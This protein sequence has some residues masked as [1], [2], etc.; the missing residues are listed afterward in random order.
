MTRAEVLEFLELPA[1]NVTDLQ[2]RQRLQEKAGY[3]ED[4]SKNAN[5][6]FL[7][8]VHSR[9]WMKVQEI[10]KE[11]PEWDASHASKAIEFPMDEAAREIMELEE[12]ASGLTMPLIVSSDK[13]K[14]AGP[15][16][17]DPPGWLIRHTEGLPGKTFIL[18]VG[19][20]YIG[21]KADP[22]LNPFIVIENDSFI[23]KV[24]AVV[25][26]EAPEGTPSFYI[27]DSTESNGGKASSNGTYVN[28]DRHRITHKTP[29]QDGD[30]IQVGSTKLVLRVNS[31]PVQEVE[32]EVKRSK[33]V[34]TIV[35]R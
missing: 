15:S 3:H 10:R 11:F 35:L 26:I 12:D 31:K 25:T 33:F 23:S 28:G 2:V 9:Y 18:S 21:R 19:A 16:M 13:T 20:N 17:P 8:L 14:L 22:V 32:R 6:D 29:L 34:D 27:N 1:E 30:T 24:Q 4:L 7:R 5:S